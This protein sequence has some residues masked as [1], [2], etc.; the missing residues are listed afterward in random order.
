MKNIIVVIILFL[1]LFSSCKKDD[2]PASSRL[3][4]YEVTGNYAGTVYASY[5]TASG[6][7]ANE[8]LTAIPWSKEVTYAA[9]VTAAIIAISGNGGI[10]GQQ[11][12]VV[13]K[14]AGSQLSTTQ[15]TADGSG[16]FT[17]AVPAI[18]F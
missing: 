16:S 11:V 1:A 8:Q 3:V 18:T 4:R 17:K 10:A 9:N 5:T 2:A 12:T 14:K 15:A 6:S 7:T 13:V